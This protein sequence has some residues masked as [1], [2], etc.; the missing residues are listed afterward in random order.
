M[1]NLFKIYFS[2]SIS[3]IILGL[4]LVFAATTSNAQTVND[5]QWWNGISEPWSFNQELS[6]NEIAIMQNRWKLI[7]DEN[8]AYK[9]NGWIGDYFTGGSTHEMYLRWSPQN[10]FVILSVNKCMAQVEDFS[11]GKVSTASNLVQFITEKAITLSKHGHSAKKQE[12]NIWV[13]VK[14]EGS[15]LLIPENRMSEFG[16]Y[17]AGLGEYNESDVYYWLLSPFFYQLSDSKI[18]EDTSSPILPTEYERFLKPPIKG[19]IVAIGKRQVRKGYS[20]ESPSGYGASSLDYVS[21]N[22]VTVNTGKGNGAKKGLRLRIVKTDEELRLIQV[23]KYTS[24]GIIVRYLDDNKK[25][26]YYDNESEQ[27]KIY[28]K[29][30]IGWKLTT[31][32]FFTSTEFLNQVKR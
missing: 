26:T 30:V 19:E 29:I 18:N 20:Y 12:S 7:E 8:K 13:Q 23:G 27:T 3:V 28:P 15:R 31:S 16:D 10:G 22:Y 11:Y 25:E 2:Q 4:L 32:P 1:Q 24:I 9:F 21:L 17:V 6:P 14:F 5:G